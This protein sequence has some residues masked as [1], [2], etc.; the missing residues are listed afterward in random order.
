MYLD[1]IAPIQRGNCE[2]PPVAPSAIHR[3]YQNG[4]VWAKGPPAARFALSV[5][6]LL[7]LGALAAHERQVGQNLEPAR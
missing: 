7:A 2:L 6:V 3:A 4:V 1:R 5:T